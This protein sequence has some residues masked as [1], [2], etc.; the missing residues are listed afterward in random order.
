MALEKYEYPATGS[1]ANSFLPTRNPSYGAVG[2]AVDEGILSDASAGGQPYNY[3]EG[4]KLKTH[5]RSYERLA[6]SEYASYEA[7]RDAVGGD[8]F[9]FTDADAA[10]HTVTFVAF[11]RD[12]KFSAGN[13]KS[14]TIEMLEII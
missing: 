10:A 13:R 1:P 14:F 4:V 7:F 2:D 11:Q 5:R 6:A 3:R 9:K 8:Q 12:P